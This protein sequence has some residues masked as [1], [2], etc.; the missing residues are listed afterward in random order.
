MPSDAARPARVGAPSPAPGRIWAALGIVYFFWGTTYFAIERSNQT[1]P[2]LVGPAARFLLAGGVLVAWSRRRGTWRRPTSRQWRAAATVGVL[3]LLSGNGF[4]AIAED[5]GVPTGIVALLI[6]LVPL[7]MALADRGVLGADRLGGRVVL[8]LAGGFVGAALLVRGQLAGHVSALGLGFAVGASLSW[9]TG[10]LLQRR[11]PLPPDPRQ[12]A[13]MQQLAGGIGLLVAAA[14]SG[15][16]GD[17][18]PARISATSALALVYLVAFGSLL[19]LSAY[20]WLLRNART[21]LVSTYAYVNPVV[22]VSLGALLGDE[23]VTATTLLAGGVV[24]ASVALI[25]SVAAPRASDARKE[26]GAQVEPEVLLEG[27]GDP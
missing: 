25:V 19:A 14:I 5:L 6:A 13:G 4:V 1:I 26:R 24:L 17:L 3:L 16:L 7:W 2:P 18:H 9:A 8:G 15:E 10:S 12:S 11:A 27:P 21:S 22:A 20:L 23:T